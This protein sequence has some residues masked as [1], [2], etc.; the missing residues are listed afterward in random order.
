MGATA[1]T[2]AK[3]TTPKAARAVWALASGK[4]GVG[5][6]TLALALA[7]VLASRG[8]RVALVDLDAQ[9]GATLA[10]GLVRP[11]DPITAPASLAHGFTIFTSGRPLAFATVEQLEQRIATA[12]ASADV[13][14]LDLS[15]SL[16]DAAHAAA[17]RAATLVLVV[18]R[19]DAAGLPN[20][21]ETTQL[22]TSAGR[23]FVVVPSI[24]GTTG[25]SREA[26]SFLRGRYGA[27]VANTA[28]PHDARAAESA[29]VGRPVTQTAKR[30]KAAA[31]L[32][33]LADELSTRA[34]IV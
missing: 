32:Q 29:G 22:A 26:E 13:V 28:I 9:G 8:L 33:A 21:A 11:D 34:G 15:P 14:L 1:R 17:M 25:L 23:P 6:S 18:A 7:D 16:T 2:S 30:S 10:A 27:A 3:S 31:A 4:G 5:K 12:A 19:T 20:V 24:K